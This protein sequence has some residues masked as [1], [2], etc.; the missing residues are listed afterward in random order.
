MLNWVRRYFLLI[1]I[2]VNESSPPGETGIYFLGKPLF[3]PLYPNLDLY[4]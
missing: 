4:A 3:N 2:N 1:L